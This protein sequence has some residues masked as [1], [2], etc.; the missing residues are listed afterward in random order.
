MFRPLSGHLPA[1]H[2]NKTDSAPRRWPD[3]EAETC[4]SNLINKFVHTVGL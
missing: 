2:V 3:I 4:R 1:A